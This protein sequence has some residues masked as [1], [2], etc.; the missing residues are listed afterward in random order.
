[1]AHL[2]HKV[3]F[4]DIANRYGL[5]LR[6]I[7]TY[8]SLYRKNAVYR[9]S[10]D[11]GKFL[12]KAMNFRTLEKNLTR[13]QHVNRVFFYIKKL[14]DCKYPNFPNW[15]TTSSGTY[16]VNKYGRH[17]YMAEWIRGRGMQ[18]DVQDY[19]A[20]G[21][22]LA[23][24]HT[25][26]KDHLSSRSMSYFTKRQINLFKLEDRLYRLR[27]P[28]IQKKK[29]IAKRWFEKHG[30]RCRALADEAWDML[31]TSE[32]KK[33]L[34]KE[35]NHP[36]LIHGD[37]TIP[38]IVVNPN[39]LFLIDWDSLRMGST[40]YEIAKTL[41]NTTFYKPVQ[42]SALL[43][44]YEEINPLKSAERLLISAL[45]RLP[46]EAWCE[47]RNIILGRSQRGFHVLEQTWDERLNAI[48]IL[49]EWARK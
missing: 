23:N 34:S 44:G 30:E 48:Q 15:L 45:F 38:N 29:T 25:I 43:R 22:A 36:A 18:D 21:R 19:E 24:L 9:A 47:V 41:S 5:R 2:Y 33:I 27:L 35:K 14:K 11:K 12:I 49:D 16:Y 31:G 42:I 7:K 37:V 20:L 40:Y 13:E 46:R 4:K 28:N 6:R 10:T 17:Y 32:V 8:D 39:G 26:C 3:W 1:M